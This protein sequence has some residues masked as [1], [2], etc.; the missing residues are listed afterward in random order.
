MA[1]KPKLRPGDLVELKSSDY[2]F[3]GLVKRASYARRRGESPM[4]Y[5]EWCGLAPRIYPQQYVEESLL[6]IVKKSK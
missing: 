1:I 2:R 3:L 4:I 6:K 5:V